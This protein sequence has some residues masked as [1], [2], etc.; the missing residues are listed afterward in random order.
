MLYKLPYLWYI[1]LTIHIPF[2]LKSVICLSS[3][4][5]PGKLREQ[6]SQDLLVVFKEVIYT[7]LHSFLI[8]F[9]IDSYHL[10]KEII[11]ILLE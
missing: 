1:Y 3:L 6:R 8:V 11:F 10:F 7:S 9:D 2:L 4:L 5:S